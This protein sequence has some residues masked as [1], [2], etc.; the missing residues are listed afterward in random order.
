[1]KLRDTYLVPTISDLNLDDVNS[2]WDIDIDETEYGKKNKKKKKKKKKS[3]KR[4]KAAKKRKKLAKKRA[5]KKRKKAQKKLKKNRMM[6]EKQYAQEFRYQL[7]I[8]ATDTAC[9]IT[10]MYFYSKF[11]SPT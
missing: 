10:K 1:M 2:W 9:D 8:K 11:G 7:L 5:A 6:A 4:K 3:K